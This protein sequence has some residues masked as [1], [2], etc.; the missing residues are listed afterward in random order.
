MTDIPTKPMDGERANYAA[1]RMLDYLD[2]WQRYASEPASD[3]P[4]AQAKLAA[5]AAVMRSMRDD[6]IEKWDEWMIHGAP[7][8]ALDF[9]D[10]G[11]MLD[12]RMAEKSARTIATKGT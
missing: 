12:P 11:P 1:R 10:F 6:V 2:R 4:H 7:A 3:F 9:S 5:L 8:E